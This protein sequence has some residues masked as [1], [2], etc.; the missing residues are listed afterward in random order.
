MVS[1]CAG[2]TV[3]TGAEAACVLGCGN[4]EKNTDARPGQQPGTD[5]CSIWVRVAITDTKCPG[6]ADYARKEKIGDCILKVCANFANYQTNEE[7]ND[8]G[9][10]QPYAD[11]I[12]QQSSNLDH[13]LHS[14]QPII[15]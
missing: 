5:G 12:A 8:E 2:A 9:N 6:D 10:D 15:I 13:V 14:L 11:H 3:A 1:I 4:Q 7:T